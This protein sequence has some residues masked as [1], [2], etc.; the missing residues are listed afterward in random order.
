MELT[1]IET[2][3][4]DPDSELTD[5]E[6]DI[7][8]TTVRVHTDEGVVGLGETF[9]LAGMET[10]A[11]HGPIARQVLGRDPRDLA[12]IHDDLATYFNYYGHAGAEWRA[13]SGLDIALWDL[14]GRVADEPIYALLGGKAREEIPAYNTSYDREYDFMDEPVALAESL[15]AAGLTSM[16]IWP[17]DEFAGKTRG[18]RISTDDLEAGLEPL[19]RVREAVGDRMDVA[20]EGHGLWALTPAKRIARAVAEYDPM[21]VEDLIRKG[22]YDAYRRLGAATDVPLCVSERLLGRYEFAQAIDT[23]AVDVVMPDVCWTGGLSEASAVAEM[24][25]ASHLPVAPHNSGG[26]VLHFANAHLAT[27]IPNLYVMETI[28][29]RYDGWHRNLVTDPLPVRDGTL[30]PPPGPGLGTRFDESL[31]DHDATEV[32]RTEA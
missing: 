22:D 23:G 5:T 7:R 19:V 4:Y 16:K 17:F 26:P 32:E 29:D 15:L 6:R 31:L 28:R 14:K 18:Q 13:L 27:A 30:D 8:I 1:A 2:I 21:W 9:P 11:L 10:A 25:E 3:T 12:G 20:I 24:A